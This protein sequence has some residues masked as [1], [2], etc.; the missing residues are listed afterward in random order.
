MNKKDFYFD[1]YEKLYQTGYHNDLTL[2]HTK[3][4]F[5]Y[6]KEVD[7]G[8]KKNKWIPSFLRKKRYSDKSVKILD[9]GCSHGLAVEQLIKM[10]YDAYGIDV[11]NTAINYCR[12]RGLT[13][14]MVGSAT[15]I[16]FE[17]NFFDII[18]STDVLEHLLIEDVEKT[19]SEFKRVVKGYCLL[20][21]AC[22]KESNEVP[23]ENVKNTFNAY[24]DLDT[25]HTT[26]I[27]PKEWDKAFLN[28]G[29]EKVRTISYENYD[30]EVIYKIS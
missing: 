24:L 9:V 29:F 30:Y 6:L 11:S 8:Y 27:D 10:G 23:L 19:V 12:D 15:D 7:G 14:C 4:L 21:I 22:D 13:T 1:L 28:K 2:S 5:P 20:G 16:P 26:I 25:L 18:I 3:K 17:D